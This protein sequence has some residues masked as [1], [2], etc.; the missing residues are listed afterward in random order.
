M[1]PGKRGLFLS[2]LRPFDFGWYDGSFIAT[3]FGGSAYNIAHDIEHR[4]RSIPPSVIECMDGG[5]ALLR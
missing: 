2:H 3:K 1:R 4:T 5:T